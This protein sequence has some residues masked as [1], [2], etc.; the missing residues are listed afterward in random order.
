[1]FRIL[2]CLIL[3]LGATA[4]K[5]QDDPYNSYLNE[6][7]RSKPSSKNSRQSLGGFADRYMQDIGASF[8]AFNEQGGSFLLPG[9]QYIGRYNL[10]EKN[11]ILGLALSTH[12]SLGFQADPFFGT[13]FMLNMPV[14]IEGTVGKGSNLFN[15]QW[16]GLSL[17]VGPEFN[18]L[19][20]FNQFGLS[21]AAT[22]RFTLAQRAY[23][24]RYSASL[25]RPTEG[26]YIS[27]ISFGNSLF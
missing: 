12:P 11:D 16:V 27:S 15:Q 9:I 6:G 4:A 2:F 5:A 13:F 26:V 1:M 19:N 25:S 24:I 3:L 18:L 10:Y 7:R 21:G 20:R 14:L 22:F 23:F 8:N 17:G